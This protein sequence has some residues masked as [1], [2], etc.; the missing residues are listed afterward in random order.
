MI[1]HHEDRRQL[2]SVGWWWP[3]L[4]LLHRLFRRQ[5]IVAKRTPLVTIA[6]APPATSQ[7]GNEEGSGALDGRFLCLGLV[8]D[9]V[10]LVARAEPRSSMSLLL[11][12]S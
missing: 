12:S 11:F 4:M 8:V 10:P 9:R 2:E 1:R 6:N 7:E 5:T 3:K